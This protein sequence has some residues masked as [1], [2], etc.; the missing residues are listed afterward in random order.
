VMCVR[1]AK[2]VVCGER[3]LER[4]WDGVKRFISVHL[5]SYP[6]ISVRIRSSPFASVHLR[7][8]WF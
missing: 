5:R 3:E 1:Y 4:W 7:M 6:F 2:D 8:L